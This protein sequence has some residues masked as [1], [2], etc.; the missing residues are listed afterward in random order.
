MVFKT[1]YYDYKDFSAHGEFEELLYD[2]TIDQKGGL[3]PSFTITLEMQGRKEG[4]IYAY[5]CRK[6]ISIL[7]CVGGDLRAESRS[8][9]DNF[10]CWAETHGAKHG[11]FEEVKA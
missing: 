10:I 5:L 9:A 7:D 8:I 3:L 2:V 1:V 11:R 6:R 4:K